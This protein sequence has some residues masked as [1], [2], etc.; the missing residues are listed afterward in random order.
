YDPFFQ[1]GN[2]APYVRA[3]TPKIDHDIG[4][5]LSWPVIGKLASAAAFVDGKTSVDQ[6]GVVRAGAS[7]V[8]RRVVPA[9]E[10]THRPPPPARRP[11][12]GPRP[13]QLA[14]PR[15][16]MVATASA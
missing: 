8:E 14:A 10:Q 1:S 4:N 3:A 16:S 2:K 7:S 15:A 6:V 13:A 12:H 11:T 9:A 5:A